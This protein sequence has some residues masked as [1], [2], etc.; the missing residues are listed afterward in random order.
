MTKL[1][2]AGDIGGTKTLLQLVEV[3]GD[4]RH[5]VYERRFDSAAHGDFNGIVGEF[6]YA[7]GFISAAAQPIVAA[8]FGVAGPI[9][10]QSAKIT[11][12]PWSINAGAVGAEFGIA[13]VHLINDFAAVGYGIEALHPDD[14]ATLQAG[15]DEPHGTRAVL[16][17]GTGLGEGLLLWRG[18]HYEALPSE[19]GHVDFAPADSEQVGLL[20]Y[21][22]PLFGHVS[23]ERIL[24]GSGLVK[25]FE[26]VTEHGLAKATPQLQ[27]AMLE[28]DPAA[29]ISEYG[30]DE[31]DPAALKALDMFVAIYG[32]QAGNLALTLLASGGVYVAG[33]IAPKIIAKLKRGGFVRAFNDKGRF[34]AL[35]QRIP[36]RVVMNQKVG[37]MGAALVASRLADRNQVE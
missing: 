2:L 21:L 5:M 28:I 32:A 30:L 23:Y 24:S 9:H 36:V 19:G 14:L 4:T 20:N 29:V 16:G 34:A 27:A 3:Q 25:I 7:A 33:G 18:D 13:K 22:Q 11:N 12:L 15:E 37:L 6:V 8:C 26:Y 17:A 1:V 31:R 10:G 35:L